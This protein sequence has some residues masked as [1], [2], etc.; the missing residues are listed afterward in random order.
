M[1]GAEGEGVDD[2]RSEPEEPRPTLMPDGVPGDWNQRVPRPVIRAAG[3][4]AAAFVATVTLGAAVQ[5]AAEG[6]LAAEWPLLVVGLVVGIPFFGLIFVAMLALLRARG[7]AARR[8][9]R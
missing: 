3:I 4:A 7:D 8:G 1:G 6:R 9:E 5:M 2:R